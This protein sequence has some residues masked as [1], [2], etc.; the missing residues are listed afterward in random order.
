M[1][2]LIVV[3]ALGLGGCGKDE[4]LNNTTDNGMVE[5]EGVLKMKSGD[6]YLMNTDEGII[7]ITSNKVNLDELIGKSIKVKG[8][9][10]GSTL[11]VDEV[12]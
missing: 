5:K 2:G 4:G 8:M 1:M 11:Y 10:S 6:E 3:A 12:E 7:N 9:Y